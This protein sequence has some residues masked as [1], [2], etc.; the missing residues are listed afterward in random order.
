VSDLPG[1]TSWVGEIYGLLAEKF[2]N[3]FFK[4]INENQFLK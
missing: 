2:A 1:R 3:N 4:K